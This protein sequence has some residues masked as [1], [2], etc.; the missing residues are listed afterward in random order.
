MIEYDE[1]AYNKDDELPFLLYLQ[2]K[3][4]EHVVG[5]MSLIR[6]LLNETFEQQQT[7]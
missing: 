5:R 6:G 7:L 1:S 2:K 4:I 3:L